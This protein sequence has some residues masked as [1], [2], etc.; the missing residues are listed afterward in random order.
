MN[1]LILWRRLSFFTVPFWLLACLTAIGN[2]RPTPTLSYNSQNTCTE[3]SKR[4]SNDDILN[5]NGVKLTSL[6]I[7][8]MN[9][10][11]SDGIQHGKRSVSL[12]DFAGSWNI[13][14]TDLE[15]FTPSESVFKSLEIF[16]EKVQE[17]IHKS[18]A[19]AA[20]RYISFKA[21]AIEFILSRADQVFPWGLVETI[22][23]FMA[24][25]TLAGFPAF[26]T[27][28]FYAV[29]GT[30]ISVVTVHLLVA[31]FI[32]LDTPIHNVVN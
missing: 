11:L 31:A 29:K 9:D 8:N 22:Q 18:M 4:G 12:K 10:T 16:Y 7:N 20:S 30:V 15:I 27:M 26:G 28:A 24:M 6:R 17:T 14:S 2:D 21:G 25:W 13:V 3:V 19:A 32:P 23:F 1:Y 5:Q